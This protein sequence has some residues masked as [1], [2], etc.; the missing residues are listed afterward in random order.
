MGN[1]FGKPFRSFV[2][3]QIQTRQESL[4]YKDYNVNDLK[5][6]NTKTPWIRLASTVDINQFLKDG[7]TETRVYQQLLKNGLNPELFTGDVAAKNFIL[8]G[9]AIAIG[10]NNE[11]KTNSG[12]NY[13]NEYY[14][15]AYGWG[16]IDEKGYVP[17]PGIKDVN[18][19][20]KSDGAF[21]EGTINM[22]CFSR[23]Q[24][25]LMDLLYMRPGVNLLLEFGWSTYLDNEGNLQTYD[26]FI[27]DALDFTL[28]K[29]GATVQKE[30]VEFKGGFD[31]FGPD[32]FRG[33][34]EFYEDM[35]DDGSLQSKIL[36][37][38]EQERIDRDGNYEGMFGM[39][40]NFNWKFNQTDGSYDCQTK[41][42]GHGD[43]IQGLTMDVNKPN[44]DKVLAEIGVKQS[45]QDQESTADRMDIP[46]ISDFRSNQLTTILIG[47][48]R[49]FK[50]SI[51]NKEN[52]P[53]GFENTKNYFRY[54]SNNVMSAN[55]DFLLAN[56]R[57]KE[58]E[59]PF[60]LNIKNGLLG[61]FGAE[62]TAGLGFDAA[63]GIGGEGGGDGIEVYMK[64]SCLLAIIQK[65]FL[66]YDEKG[67]PLCYFDMNFSDLDN[68][69]NYIA[70][71]PGQFSGNP[72]HVLVPYENV[73]SSVSDITM[74]KTLLGLIAESAS[75]NFLSDKGY[76][77][78]LSEVLINVNV[79]T[80]IAGSESI[81]NSENDKLEITKFLNLVLK[82][83]NKT[84]GGGN[85]FRVIVE[86]S[87]STIKIIDKTPIRWKTALP[88]GSTG[89]EL[90]VFNT[91][92]VKNKI[93]GSIVKSIDIG[94]SIGKDMA[95]VIAINVGGG[96]NGYSSNGTGLTKWSEGIT[97]RIFPQIGDGVNG[98]ESEDP[99]TDVNKI[100]DENITKFGED[101]NPFS[102]LYDKCKFNV[103]LMPA[104][105]S[106]CKTWISKISGNMT[107][108]NFVT[109]PYF[110]PFTFNMDIE[111]I[112][113]IRLYE[114]FDIDDNVL[115]AT[116]DNE[117][118]E[119]QISACDHAVNS[120]SWTTKIVA[121]PQP[122]SQEAP[123]EEPTKL[124]G[125]VIVRNVVTG[126][127]LDDTDLFTLTSAYPILQIFKTEET[128]KRQ[129]YLHHTVSSQNIESVLF[130]WSSRTD[131]VATHYITNNDGESEQVFPDE[132][133][134]NQLGIPVSLFSSAGL[135]YQ[136]LNK[137]ALGIELCSYGGLTVEKDQNGNN[138]YFTTYGQEVSASN[139]AQPV[140]QFGQPI[141]FKGYSHFEKYNDT[142]INNVKSIIMGWMS[143]YDIE[144]IYNYSELFPQTQ[145]SL[146]ALSG[147]K[148]VYT[149]NSVR[150][151]KSDVF[152][153][154]ELLD[155][156]KS[157]ATELGDED[158]VLNAGG[159]WTGQGT[160][161]GGIEDAAI[162]K[163]RR[164][165]VQQL[166]RDTLGEEKAKNYRGA[167]PDLVVKSFS[168]T[169]QNVNV[170]VLAGQLT[171][172][173]TFEAQINVFG[174]NISISNNEISSFRRETLNGVVQYSPI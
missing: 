14:N 108:K 153:Q 102:N 78:K 83:I 110:L 134:A 111:G 161:R 62:V 10:E 145:I 94:S 7:T 87:T 146:N 22:K 65:F 70:N 139:V 52:V 44:M 162:G 170:G 26:T 130:G 56:F 69:P 39:I 123:Y 64:F 135:S 41:I 40:T 4:G 91:Y 53:I 156:L 149:H 38:I 47:Y 100:W 167:V 138:K 45:R 159:Q 15:G 106:V 82:Q 73:L 118:L 142:Q 57:S 5:Y 157:I 29:A 90:C 144:F 1:I 160:S 103:L 17:M 11:L 6:Q 81:K 151:D 36:Q 9:G 79:L 46:L 117:S 147:N 132:N 92:G 50:N 88:P 136:N 60:D 165:A 42:I 86:A 31:F 2:T 99:K 55:Q 107:D 58:K 35:L 171:V 129:V 166:I 155:M 150:T 128:Q 12:L 101:S 127:S 121:I 140:N 21:A 113:G 163:A 30:K 154:K 24:L 84:R 169:N 97:D 23:S 148:G 34:G 174:G 72:Y 122:S 133:W 68:D 37:L 125:G 27:T 63:Q 8:Q 116:Y 172:E 143:K 20:Y 19:I 77:G 13:K 109:S 49:K 48:Y 76:A 124:S 85:D 71:Y 32:A 95:D 75:P 43:V 114:R 173:A 158:K 61:L 16:G 98:E 119:M 51:A 66:L 115:P 105:E 54:K 168:E 126:L 152:P 104:Y 164:A 131:Q 33:T 89:T 18:I 3:K 112:S 59:E 93:G 80:N 120:T 28:N 67:T 141:N 137:T 96:A 74:P 25:I